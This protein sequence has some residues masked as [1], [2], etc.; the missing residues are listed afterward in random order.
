MIKWSLNGR[1]VSCISSLKRGN[2]LLNLEVA[3]IIAELSM[4]ELK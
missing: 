2:D 4:F 1:P 3:R